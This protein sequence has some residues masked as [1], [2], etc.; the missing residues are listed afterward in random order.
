M[1]PRKVVYHQG[2]SRVGKAAGDMVQFPLSFLPSD[3]GFEPRLQ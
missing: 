2:G 1:Y 3:H